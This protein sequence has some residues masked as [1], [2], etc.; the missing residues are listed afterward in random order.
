MPFLKL[1]LSKP[2]P[3]VGASAGAPCDE[4]AYPHPRLTQR[5]REALVEELG[6]EPEFGH[7]IIYESPRESRRAHPSR[8]Q[9]F[10]FCEVLMHAGRA[11]EMKQRLLQRLQKEIGD[12]TGLSASDVVCVVVESD[13]RNWSGGLTGP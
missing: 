9:D 3:S 6:I 11:D 4:A 8:G 1:H 7:V 12:G 2:Q 10:A 5:L 13:R